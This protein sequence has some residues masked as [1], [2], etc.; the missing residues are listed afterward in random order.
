VIAWFAFLRA[1][2]P[3][4]HE[5]EPNDDLA[6]ATPIALDSAV[7]GYLG[8]RIGP[9]EPDR[10]VYRVLGTDDDRERIVSVHLSGIPNIDES[11]TLRD[12]AGHAIAVIGEGGV[13]S[14]EAFHRRRVRGEIIVEVGEVMRAG[15]DWPI[16]NVSDAYELAVAIDDKPGWEIE[17]DGT[18]S[19][20]VPIADNE[21]VRGWLDSRRDVDVLRW[22]GPPGRYTVTVAADPALPITWRVGNGDAGFGAGALDVALEPGELIALSRTDANRPDGQPLPG[23]EDPW[24]VTVTPPR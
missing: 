23:E 19:D 2:P 7:T 16:E 12:S 3:Q 1:T 13:G 20:A 15:Q 9:H 21:T 24:S 8:K 10:D 22:N 6:D 17:P 14:G 11:L 5:R 4:T 18:A